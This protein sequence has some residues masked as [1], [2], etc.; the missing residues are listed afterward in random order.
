M[1][2]SRPMKRSR[3]VALTTLGAAGAVALQACGSSDWNEENAVTAYPYARVA[4]CTAD[5]KVPASECK[6]A[7]NEALANDRLAA[8]RFDSLGLCE[9]QFGSGQ[10]QQQRAGGTSFWAPLLA[11]FVIGEVIDEIGDRRRYRRA[12]L[13]RNRRDDSWYTGGSSGGMLYRSGGSYRVGQ[14]ALE[15]PRSAPRVQTRSSVVSRGGFGGR[16]R[17]GWGG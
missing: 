11:G 12:G 4:E 13:Y 5:G 9:D 6:A 7:Y 14:R 16:A 10:C 2:S 17:G 1:P 8:P 15:A 3:K